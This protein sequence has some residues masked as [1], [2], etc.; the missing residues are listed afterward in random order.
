MVVVAVD[1]S[2]RLLVAGRLVEARAVAS[3]AYARAKEQGLDTAFLPHV[4]VFNATAAALEQGLTET[5]A[6]LVT[7]LTDHP[8]R[9]DADIL[10][11]LR[12]EVDLRHGL[13]DEA[14]ARITSPSLS[15]SA[16]VDEQNRP[17]H[18][19]AVDPS[20]GRPGQGLGLGVALDLAERASGTDSD[21]LGS[22]LT[23]SAGAAADLAA[24]AR[25]RHD[26][27]ALD[28]P[29]SVVGTLRRLSAEFAGG[30]RRRAEKSG[31]RLELAAELRR[32]EGDD[33][34]ADWE[35]VAH[36]WTRWGRP[37]RAAYSWWR[38]AQSVWTGTPTGQR[39]QWRCSTPSTPRPGTCPSGA[40]SPSWPTGP[41][42][43][44]GTRAP[45][46]TK[47]WTHALPVHLTNQETKVLRLVAAGMTNAQIGAEL[48]ISPKTVSVHVSN[49]LRK[50][51]VRS[52]VQAAAWAD[53]VGLAPG[54]GRG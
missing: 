38:L 20:L 33:R 14:L 19:R 49:L 39:S 23:S 51:E 45:S 3:E 25:A 35:G 28:E 37:H 31:E 36:E 34:P 10:A 17:C 29:G 24:A 13:V 43:V 5:A 47:A 12:A 30:A 54:H 32:A 53:R 44:S 48:F 18:A 8:L 6:E 27:G 41:G 7:D 52:R 26:D 15:T 16:D 50:L 11:D 4:L 21:Y 1:R 40:W 42:S 9:K 22:L 46:R 2:D